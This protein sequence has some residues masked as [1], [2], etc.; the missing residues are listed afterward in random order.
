MP[1]PSRPSPDSETH[2]LR[3]AQERGI[4]STDQ[5][6]EAL[7]TRQT[8]GEVGMARAIEDIL[9]ERGVFTPD[10]V[11]ALRQLA[12]ETMPT[13][14]ATVLAGWERTTPGTRGG[15]AAAPPDAVPG[16]PFGRY[17]LMEP[18]GHGGM[19]IVWKAWDTDLR[20]V[21]AL[22]QIL[23][24]DAVRGQTIERFL[25]EARA[26]A[27]LRHPNIVPVYD[28][29]VIDGKHYLTADF[30]DGTSLDRR[31]GEEM[32][33]RDAVGLVKTVAEALQYAHDQ[34]VVHRDIKPGNILVDR[35]GVPHVA[36]FGLAKDASPGSGPALTVSGDLLG[37]PSY[38]S[39]E[40]ARGR[41][42][43]QGP[44]SDQFSLGVMMYE[45]VT[46]K[47]PFGGTSLQDILNAITDKDPAPP[48]SYQKKLHADVETVILKT[49]EKD[50][51]KRYPS[52]RDLAA[53]LGRILDAEPIEARRPGLA[54]R[55][56]RRVVKH[57]TLSAAVVV[58]LLGATMGGMAWW[59]ARAR[60]ESE[61]ARRKT[62]LVQAVLVRWGGMAEPIR[63]L[64]MTAWDDVLPAERRV[65]A[66]RRAWEE[67]SRFMQV[68]PKD[69]TSQA[70]MRSL[71]G[72]A[73]AI[74]G[75][76]EEGLSWLAESK[77]LDPDLPF[78]AL[79]EALLLLS[80]YCL[81]APLPAPGGRSSEASP[82]LPEESPPQRQRRERILALVDEARRARITAGELADGLSTALR[83]L[84]DVRLGSYGE[85][86]RKL[87]TA[88][89]SGATQW[90]RSP[91]LLWRA[92]VRRQLGKFPAALDDLDQVRRACPRLH[93]VPFLM[94]KVLI[95]QGAAA[96]AR[97]E[98][99]DELHA[100]ALKELTSAAEAPTLIVMA[101][102]DRG[103]VHQRI[104]EATGAR[105]GDPMPE[106]A[107]AI[108]DLSEAVDRD[109]SNM[110]G[111][112]N[113]ALAHIAR[114][115]VLA[116]AGGDPRV[117][118]GA[119]RADLDLVLE[120]E[121][122]NAAAYANRALAR[123]E[124]AAWESGAKDVRDAFRA[125][126][127]DL[128]R[129]NRLAPGVLETENDLGVAWFRLAD[130]EAEHGGNALPPAREAVSL[131]GSVLARRP[132]DPVVLLNRGL[133]SLILA[134]ARWVHQEDPR[135]DLDVAAEHLRAH[136]SK[137]PSPSG[138]VRY[139]YALALFLR[140]QAEADSGGDPRAVWKTA[141][142]QAAEVA[143]GDP[144]HFRAWALLTDLHR[145]EGD[146]EQA[147]EACRRLKE[148]Q[149]GNQAFD[150]VLAYLT[151]LRSRAERDGLKG[152]GLLAWLSG[153]AMQ[154]GEFSRARLFAEDALAGAPPESDLDAAGRETVSRLRFDLARV[155]ARLAA[156]V[157][158]RHAAPFDIGD[159][160]REGHRGL[161]LASLTSAI[162]L[163]WRDAR[164]LDANADLE[165]LRSDPRWKGL[166]DSLPR[167]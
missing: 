7:R 81:E 61:T 102:I 155:H 104:A 45:M 113:R 58:G 10:Q 158:G 83:S 36:D 110:A 152:W 98:S 74:G 87:T 84:E 90:C 26:A 20:R 55:T 117:D 88:L 18:L 115:K 127:E 137:V 167:K 108:Q 119:A 24:G 35:Q 22:K 85:A 51:A 77:R 160:G 44:A 48:T 31:M 109:P 4:L 68:T 151:D 16:D 161:A 15:A 147:V 29:G 114:A 89:D 30:V 133:A 12:Q 69:E 130:E 93:L 164:E 97:G 105:G 8:L 162:E 143:K 54:S 92:V 150:S 82:P 149:P 57:K 73:R 123:N 95:D 99:T 120:R 33:V 63:E 53:D 80:Q 154:Q 75:E 23:G 67:I 146:L 153:D 111:Y 94:G 9:F 106:F 101:L 96:S 126:L 142:T 71:A 2:L 32:S 140:G 122:E 60:D 145:Q 34:G 50:P 14:D 43:E 3:T 17:R 163:G 52:M 11:R 70:A 138:E 148:L 40:Q 86:E 156:P 25:R 21:V 13:S 5:V 116:R 46:G 91:F 28:V 112:Y 56:M 107:L 144:T 129:A 79:M 47:L 42:D 1:D 38:M 19:G 132:S 78:G 39:P 134:Q 124:I 121:P 62:E 66:N 157:G 125:V 37:T 131:L 59:N 118:Y 166:V 65:E 100:Q 136:L 159:A 141:F 165:P 103:T 27:R 139:R 135:G 64:Q 128:Q 6:E 41:P 72:W 49:L 76:R